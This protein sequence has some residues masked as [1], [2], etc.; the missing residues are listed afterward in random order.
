MDRLAKKM[1]K[2]NVQRLFP[3]GGIGAMVDD[4]GRRNVLAFKS[5]WS[6]FTGIRQTSEHAEMM[7][8]P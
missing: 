3:W 5:N 2:D 6:D 4:T 1:I 8:F 7:I